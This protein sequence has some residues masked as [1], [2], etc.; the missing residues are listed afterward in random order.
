MTGSQRKRWLILGPLLLATLAA[1]ALVEDDDPATP[2]PRERRV[3]AQAGDRSREVQPESP[4]ALADFLNL[5]DADEASDEN[6]QSDPFRIKS[7]V[8]TPPPA[9]PPAPTAPPLPF[10]YL[11]RILDEGRYTVFLSQ[12]NKYL[13]A[14]EGDRIGN[15]YRVESI[16][17][18]RM[19]VLYEPLKQV[20]ELV[21]GS[22]DKQ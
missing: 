2:A 3:A 20:Q 9:P 13:I 1:V 4:L 22:G 17:E 11:G 18:N 14:R 5:P 8:V 16:T 6:E 10:K 7:W 15:D 19:T 21:M 12:E